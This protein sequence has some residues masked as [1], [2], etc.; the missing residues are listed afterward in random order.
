M[1]RGENAKSGQYLQFFHAVKEAEAE[2][3]RRMVEMWVAQIPENW[4]AARDFLERRF[5]DR[6]SRRERLENT[7]AGGGPVEVTLS[8]GDR[9]DSHS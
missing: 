3:E 7:G 1:E 8:L 4:Q 2:A 6:W 5:P 9:D